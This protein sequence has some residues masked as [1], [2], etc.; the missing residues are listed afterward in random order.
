MP[1]PVSAIAT[2]TLI[3]A[4]IHWSYGAGSTAFA[5]FAG[6]V[7]SIIFLAVRNLATP[8]IVHAAFDAFYFTGGVAL[9]W[10]AVNHT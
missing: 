8:V 9:L 3:F 7:L 4:A 6:L 2:S 5:A 10:R 1:S